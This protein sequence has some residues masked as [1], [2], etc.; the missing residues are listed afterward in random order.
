MLNRLDRYS[1]FGLGALPM[2]HAAPGLFPS[3]GLIVTDRRCGF[4]IAAGS[5]CY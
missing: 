5:S 3:G 4:V 2:E 1:S